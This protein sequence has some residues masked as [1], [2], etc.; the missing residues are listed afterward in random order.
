MCDADVDGSHITTLILT[1]FFRY[2]KELVEEMATSILLRPLFI[3]LKKAKSRFIAG[4]KRSAAIQKKWPRG[5][6]ENW[7]SLQRYKGL[8]EMNAEPA[9]E[10]TAMNPIPM[11]FA[12]YYH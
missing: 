12:S 5:G 2:M 11:H 9:Y 1:F 8:G 4:P 7:S 10:E 6:S 3:L